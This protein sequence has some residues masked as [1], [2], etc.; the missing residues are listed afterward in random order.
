MDAFLLYLQPRTRILNVYGARNW[1]QGMN[2]ASLC[3]LAGRYDNHIPPRFLAPID[4]FKNS[5]SDVCQVPARFSTA[6]LLTHTAE[7][8]A[9]KNTSTIY[10]IISCYLVTVIAA[11]FFIRQILSQAEIACWDMAIIWFEKRKKL[12]SA[13]AYFSSCFVLYFMLSIFLLEISSSK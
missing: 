6:F 13:F 7:L 11:N 8:S 10:N 3:S 9:L 2:S 5:S 12:K 4:F 1:F